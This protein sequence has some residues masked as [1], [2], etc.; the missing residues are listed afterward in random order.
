VPTQPA[1]LGTARLNNFRLNYLTAAQAAER[2]AKVW[3]IIG[4]IDVTKPTS[5]TR[6]IHLQ[7]HP[8]WCRARDRRADRSL[9]R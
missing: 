6:V 3:I 2:P 7:P 4:G 5:P 8:L 1:V 9:G